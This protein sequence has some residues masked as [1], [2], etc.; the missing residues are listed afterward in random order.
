MTS[1]H[2]FVRPRDTKRATVAIILA[3]LALAV[4]QSAGDTSA[5]GGEKTTQQGPLARQCFVETGYCV[6]PHFSTYW[7]AKGGLALNGY[8]ISDER[9]EVIE[10]GEAY[11]VQYFERV[12]MEYHPE[13]PPQDRVVLSSSGLHLHGEADPSLPTPTGPLATDRVYV[14][15]TGHFIVGVFFNYWLVNGGT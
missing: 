9:A 4:F 8:P 5:R 1:R 11:T 15:E 3:A 2:Q 14:A 6:G 13:E 7:E 12:R 10:D